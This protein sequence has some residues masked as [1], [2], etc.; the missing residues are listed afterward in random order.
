[1]PQDYI[2]GMTLYNIM[3]IFH[4]RQQDLQQ[5]KNAFILHPPPFQPRGTI[6]RMLGNQQPPRPSNRHPPPAHQ[7]PP[8]HPEKPPTSFL[9]NDI[10]SGNVGGKLSPKEDTGCGVVRPW[11][12]QGS[13]RSSSPVAE[14]DEEIDVGEEKPQGKVVGKNSPLDALFKMT[15]K[16]FDDSD[17][18]G[19]LGE[20]NNM[21]HRHFIAIRLK[22]N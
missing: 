19:I 4:R 18:S 20:G 3:E 22:K 15:S 5:I 11:D 9:I 21:F 17:G 10:L 16:T 13:S 14:P 12:D 2:S 8:T 7:P 1:M 6:P